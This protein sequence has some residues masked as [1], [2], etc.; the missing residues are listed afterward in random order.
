MPK[1]TPV[2]PPATKTR[3][4]AKASFHFSALF[5]G[6]IPFGS[7]NPRWRIHLSRA[8]QI[9]SRRDIGG[10]RRRRPE[11]TPRTQLRPRVEEIAKGR[12]YRSCQFLRNAMTRRRGC[13]NQ[14]ALRREPTRS[15]S[16]RNGGD[17]LHR[18]SS[19][20]L[21]RRHVR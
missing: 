8:R 13:R 10:K 7:P 6:K 3:R 15:H 19:C 17:D 20:V 14:T 11:R 2:I 4:K 21:P 16:R 1:K 9:S 5:I 18:C 12:Q